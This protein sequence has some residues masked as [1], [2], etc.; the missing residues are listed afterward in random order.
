MQDAAVGLNFDVSGFRKGIRN[1]AAAVREGLTPRSLDAFN[2][3]AAES[4]TKFQ[5][6]YS[7]AA[8]AINGM[9]GKFGLGSIDQQIQNLARATFNYTRE[10]VTQYNRMAD[11]ATSVR[12]ALEAQGGPQF[13][14][15]WTKRLEDAAQVLSTAMGVNKIETTMAQSMFLGR[16]ASPDQAVQL[17]YLS[18]TYAKKNEKEFLETSR[19]VADAAAG[20]TGAAKKLGLSVP[21]T[22]DQRVDGEAAVAEMFRQFGGIGLELT[23]SNEL[24]ASALTDLQLKVGEDLAPAV[25]QMQRDIAEI[26]RGLTIMFGG[27]MNAARGG[28]RV[29]K[30][31]GVNEQTVDIARYGVQTIGPQFG[32]GGSIVS[33][34][35]ILQ[36]LGEP[37]IATAQGRI[38]TGRNYSGGTPFS[39][40][41]SRA[42]DEDDPEELVD[43][44]EREIARARKMAERDMSRMNRTRTRAE[45]PLAIRIYSVRPDRFRQ[46]PGGG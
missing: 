44:R 21:A 26:L 6:Q 29:L 40:P 30:A 25:N 19:L 41:G 18:A 14:Q 20:K 35:E 13:A 3:A 46:A 37:D 22:G 4:A 43:E 12:A 17:A 5:S 15:A 38:A 39:I 9:L 27:A 1:A 11:A 42:V 24:V 34:L 10:A 33:S 28:G 32:P 16:G 7:K 31:V 8:G 36:R 45:E 23:N 2:K